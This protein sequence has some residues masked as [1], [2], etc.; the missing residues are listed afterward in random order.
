[1]GI[2]FESGWGER[3]EI[4][5]IAEAHSETVPCITAAFALE[6]VAARKLRLSTMNKK[7]MD[8]S[9]RRRPLLGLQAIVDGHLPSTATLANLAGRLVGRLRPA[10]LSLR[11][12][13][14]GADG[15]VTKAERLFQALRLLTETT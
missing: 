13:R 1:V 5:I 15:R 12:G 3:H 9:A 11:K 10:L 2:A 6:G 14:T 8:C 4:V 7:E